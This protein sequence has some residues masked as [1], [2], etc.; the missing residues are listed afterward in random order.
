MKRSLVL[1]LGLLF[2]SLNSF[3][4]TKDSINYGRFG[5]IIVYHPKGTPTSVAL[6][7]SGDGGWEHGVINM[8][9][10]ICRQGALVLGIDARRYNHSLA[11]LNSEC[12]YPAADFEQLSLM[13]Q[14]K[15][16]METYTKPVLMGYSYGATLA[17]GILA[18]A[19]ANT[20]RG[21]IAIGFCPDIELKKPLCKGNGITQHVLE[22][23]KS[24]YLERTQTLTAPFMVINGV[25]DSTCPFEATAVFL[26]DLPRAELITLP[27]VGHGF[28]ISDGWLTQ[29]NA[30][31]KKILATPLFT[32]AKVIK[33][34]IQ[35]SPKQHPAILPQDFA[36]VAVPAP[37]KNNLP[38]IFM[39]SGDGGW[40][41]FD[42]SLAEALAKKGYS[43]AGMDAQKYFWKE[44][45]PESTTADVSNALSYYLEHFEKGKFVL[46][47]YSFGAS[48]LPFI[49]S[50]LNKNLK[51][52]LT[53]L[54]SLS[55][56]VTADFEIHIADMLSLNSND[57]TYN[58]LAETKKIKNLNLVCFFGT[59]EE[60]KVR[61]EFENQGIKTILIPGSHHFNNNFSAV[62]DVL[63]AHI[64]Q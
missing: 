60:A 49:A 36:T 31:Y 44:K 39:I 1:F 19:P 48:V 15:Y 47:G 41:S 11:K 23:G 16:K 28:K 52:K 45:T 20:F 7:V 13:I 56:D 46:A 24:F 55:P 27:K 38:M 12:Y 22:P 53:G 42:Q 37:V 62:A 9:K 5:K 3:S 8:A 34:S 59:E 2:F 35:L 43:V 4:I 18:Q 54:L 51:E 64:S 26:K 58:V 10:D 32:E 40:T 61:K 63:I 30:A 14:K 17:Y 57:D 33:P 21:A 6:F 25:K 29:L 50:R